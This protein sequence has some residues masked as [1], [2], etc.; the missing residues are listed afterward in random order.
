MAQLNL[1]GKA[2]GELLQQLLFILYR[3][4]YLP[5]LVLILFPFLASRS[6]V[7]LTLNLVLR[8]AGTRRQGELVGV[9]Y[10]RT[11]VF[12]AAVHPALEAEPPAY[13]NL[14]SLA[15]IF[16][17]Q[18]CQAV[19]GFYF[20]EFGAFFSGAFSFDSV[21]FGVSDIILLMTRIEDRLLLQLQQTL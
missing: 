6:V 11:T 1:S 12:A 21:G 7:N 14:G 20:V 2:A 15:E 4:L 13:C 16:A 3:F 19:P 10:R 8:D 18:V 17:G 9:N 5:R